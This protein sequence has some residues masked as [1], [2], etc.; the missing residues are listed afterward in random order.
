MQVQLARGGQERLG[1]LPPEPV[2]LR[3][4]AV[5]VPGEADVS[6]G[7]R[8]VDDRVGLGREHAPPRSALAGDLKV[9]I[10]SCPRSSSCGMS[11]VP[12]APLAP[13]T[14]TLIVN[15]LAVSVRCSG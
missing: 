12:I 5:E 8:L 7:G 1:A 6:E 9:P 10:T 11:L 14:K 3:E 13:A 2:G 15:V 4:A